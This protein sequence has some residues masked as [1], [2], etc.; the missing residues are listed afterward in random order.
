MST[1]RLN[2]IIL[3][4]LETT[5]NFEDALDYMFES[6]TPNEYRDTE[7]FFK[8][9]K[10]HNQTIGL[11]N[12]VSQWSAFYATM[13]EN[14]DNEYQKAVKAVKAMLKTLPLKINAHVLSQ[15]KDKKNWGYVGDMNSL[16]ASLE[17][18]LISIKNYGD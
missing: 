16:K 6:L 1:A 12:I 8:W 9:L 11:G 18:I 14:A 15:K 2:T 4:A 7:K 5:G 13:A 17:E 3:S 10:L